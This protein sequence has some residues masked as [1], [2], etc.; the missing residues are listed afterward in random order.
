[1]IAKLEARDR[2]DPNRRL[3]PKFLVVP[4]E[5]S[6]DEFAPF[7]T[8]FGITASAT[9]ANKEVLFEGVVHG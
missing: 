8:A 5:L 4:L 9:D 2:A 3:A 7:N 1:V 6:M